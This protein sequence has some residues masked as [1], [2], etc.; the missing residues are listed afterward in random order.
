MNSPWKTSDAILYDADG[1]YMGK[2]KEYGAKA[3]P[4]QVARAEL[5]VKAI[6]AWNKVVKD[7]E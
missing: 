7:S 3:S 2:T 4:E 5:I 1:N 6:N